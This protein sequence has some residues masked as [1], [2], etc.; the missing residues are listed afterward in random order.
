MG[1]RRFQS[2][3]LRQ[4]DGEKPKWYC[5]YYKSVRDVAGN[6]RRVEKREYFGFVASVKP[7]EAKK[8]HGKFIN[9][10]NRDAFGVIAEA[11]V[12][13]WIKEYQATAYPTMKVSSQ[14]LYDS[15]IENHIE[16]YWKEVKFTDL[17][18]LKVQRFINALIAKGLAYSTRAV[19]MKIFRS[20]INA[21]EDIELYKGP[22]LWRKLRYGTQ[23]SIND[24]RALSPDEFRAILTHMDAEMRVMAMI[25]AVTGLRVC[26]LCAL[27]WQD[28]DLSA[29]LIRVRQRRYKGTTTPPKSGK[30]YRQV[31]LAGL[32]PALSELPKTGDLIFGGTERH[33]EYAVDKAATD[34]KCNFKGFGWHTLRRSYATW[35]F[36]RGT[37]LLDLSVSMGHANIEMTRE[38]IRQSGGLLPGQTAIMQEVVQ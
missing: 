13:E 10:L 5:R 4:T 6:E 36:Q 12:G 19:V 18:K 29:Q 8:R 33:Y 1:R 14:G 37:D 38:Y 15:H 31:S 11:T 28:V 3:E 35:S 26:E 27:R 21:A 2:P 34:A 24:R 22:N 23:E 25:A 30:A 16:P 7:L 20:I 9:D 32:A 17:D